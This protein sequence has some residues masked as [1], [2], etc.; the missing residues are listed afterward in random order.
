MDIQY[1]TTLADDAYRLASRWLE[2]RAESDPS[3]L[4]DERDL[5]TFNTKQKGLSSTLLSG[6]AHV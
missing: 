6:Y 4:F 3:R 2:S 1:D 5:S